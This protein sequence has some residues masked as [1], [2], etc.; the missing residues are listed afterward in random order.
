VIFTT[1]GTLKEHLALQWFNINELVMEVVQPWLC[2]QS[3]K[4]FA[5]GIPRYP[6]SRPNVLQS[7]DNI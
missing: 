3:K 5:A 6:K 2:S 7:K 1:F 4:F